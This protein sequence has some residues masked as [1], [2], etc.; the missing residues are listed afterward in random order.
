MQNLFKILWCFTHANKFIIF[1]VLL[2]FFHN[3]RLTVLLALTLALG[4]GH[5]VITGA[6]VSWQFLG[7]RKVQ[8]VRTTVASMDDEPGK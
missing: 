3:S 7:Y 2:A 8:S 4:G 6:K 5:L 1:F